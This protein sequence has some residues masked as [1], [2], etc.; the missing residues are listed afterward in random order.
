[1]SKTQDVELFVNSAS[2]YSIVD[3]AGRPVTIAA[4]REHWDAGRVSNHNLAFGRLANLG[5]DI[6][7]LKQH[8]RTGGRP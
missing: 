3:G 4:A 8:Y 6:E 7:K 1:M 2:D 5:F